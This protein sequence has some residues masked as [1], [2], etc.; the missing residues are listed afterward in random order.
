M[1]SFHL[2]DQHVHTSYS[3]D[4][5]ANIFEYA[6]VA[7][8]L[9]CKYFITTDHVE[10]ESVYNHTDWTVDY[11]SLKLD[12][13]KIKEIYPNLTPLLGIEIGYRKDKLTKMDEMLAKYSFDLVN[14][15][16]H[17]NGKVD[18]YKNED[19]YKYGT[20]AMLDIYFNNMLDGVTTYNNFDVLS[21]LDY[22]FKTAYLLDNS[23]LLSDYEEIL[24]KI[25]MVIIKKDKALEVNIKVQTNLKTDEFLNYWLRL[26]HSL[27]GY[28]LTLSSDSHR[29]DFYLH[30]HLHFIKI[31]K[32]AGFN[33]LRYYIK[34]KEYIYNI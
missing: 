32:E 31:I 15:S 9:G 30:N 25:M 26:Y 10:F 4:S 17:D 19:Y 23:I 20:R 1:E 13:I 14:M 28:K 2:H 27:G 21:H 11:D 18:Y 7:N 33:N 6:K 22:G 5:Q 3:L 34:R 8:D 12:L 24:K 29:T 16:I